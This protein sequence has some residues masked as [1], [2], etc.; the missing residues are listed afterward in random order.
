MSL[1]KL[2]CAS[3]KLRPA[4][5]SSLTSLAFALFVVTACSEGNG[6]TA[7]EDSDEDSTKETD[8]GDG[9]G[10]GDGS[11]TGGSSSSG[12]GGSTF[13]GTGG[14]TFVSPSAYCNDRE[15]DVTGSFDAAQF[16]VPTGWMGDYAKVEV[17]EAG[18]PDRAPGATG[19]CSAFTYTPDG[20]DLGWA[21]VVWQYPANNWGDSAPGL[22]AEGATKVTFW[23]KGAEGGEVVGFSGG[24]T[25]LGETTLTTEWTKYEFNLTA[26]I[27]NAQGDM[28]G[29]VAGFLW[30]MGQGEVPAPKTIYIDH[31]RWEA[32]EDG[33][34]GAP[35]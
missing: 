31:I 20:A 9:D 32:G 21:G 7:D 11:G 24:G 12:S 18:C 29:I 17:P 8:G 30:T 28:G 33:G 1:I 22:C 13:G 16:F 3:L 6:T 19:D 2:S 14:N 4:S 25:D 10:D 23:A 15:P 26:T 35:N 5:L 34:G 27:Y